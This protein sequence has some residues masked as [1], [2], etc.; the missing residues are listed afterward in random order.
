MSKDVEFDVCSLDKL[1][2]PKNPKILIIGGGYAGLMTALKLQSSLDFTQEN[3]PQVTLINKHDYHYQTTLLHKVAV[4]TLS[5]RKARIYYRKILKANK[6]K[7]VKDKIKSLDPENH[8]VYGNGGRY[9]Y[10]ILVIA[11]GFRADDF[12]IP[13]V[14]QHAFKLSTLNRAVKLSE[15]IENKFK[16]F[17]HTQNPLD[18]SF[19]VCGTGFTSIE[20]AAELGSQLDEFCEICGIDR[21]IPKITCIGRSNQI[22]PVFSEKL[23]SKAVEKLKKMSVE[24]ITNGTV[25][26][27]KEDGVI[28]EKDSKLI[29]IKGNTVLWGA[30]VKGSDVIEKSSI[31]NKKGKIQV[32]FQLRALN[33]NNIFVVGDSAQP[34]TKDAIHAPTAQLSSQMGEFV[35]TMISELVKGHEFNKPFVFKHRGTVCSIGH[36]DGVGIVYGKELWGEIAA[37]MKNTIE[38]RWLFSIGGLSM[39][40]KKGQFRYRTS[41]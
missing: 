17:I 22:L 36:T 18:L 10:D 34:T 38:N 25:K 8:C 7:F 28:V 39:V 6:V 12:N 15:H 30:G 26:E 20:F 16:D 4:G 33:Y 40:F 11:L 21:S 19:I 2:L 9:D 32:D 41:N 27:I 1:K 24:L 37:F 35:G 3:K 31:P 14:A 29:E 13:G 23:S 5:V